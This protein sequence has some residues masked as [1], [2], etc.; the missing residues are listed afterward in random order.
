MKEVALSA[1]CCT[2]DKFVR[3]DE[4]TSRTEIKLLEASSDAGVLI[5]GDAV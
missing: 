4:S 3:G 5:I 1:R 2:F